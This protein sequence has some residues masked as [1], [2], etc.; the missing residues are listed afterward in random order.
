MFAHCPALE[1]LLMYWPYHPDNVD[2]A[3]IGRLC[4]ALRKIY[5]TASKSP[6]LNGAWPFKTLMTIPKNQVETFDFGGQGGAPLDGE[7]IGDSLLRHGQSLRTIRIDHRVPSMAI[8]GILNECVVLED[9]NV[10]LSHIDLGDA[11]AASPW[12]SSRIRSLKL[13]IRIEQLPDH[14]GLP[15][16]SKYRPFY[17]RKPPVLLP[18]E[19]RTFERLEVLYRQIG[20]QKELRLLQLSTRE[21]DASGCIVG[22][23]DGVQPFPG[24]LRLKD[25]KKNKDMEMELPGY[26]ELLAGLS[27]LEFVGS[28]VVPETD[29]F[30][31]AE[32]AEEV[33]WILEHWPRL[34]TAGFI[35]SA[36]M[37]TRSCA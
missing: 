27:K 20:K 15:R 1:H 4:P 13:N 10:D 21:Y 37:P 9:L 12:A 7:F 35:P 32:D 33:D 6:L 8:R 14:P 22:L 34:R 29:G 5:Y 19:E 24:M 2:G 16:Q 25:K 26:L 17:I 11:V 18:G 28:A 23:F 3:A 30:K 36:R 31:L